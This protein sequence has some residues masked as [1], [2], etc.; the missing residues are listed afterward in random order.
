MNNVEQLIDVLAKKGLTLGSVES[1]TGGLFAK[2]ITDVSGASKVFKGALVTYSKDLKVKLLGMDE[3][4]IDDNG[5]VSW[6]VAQQM[7]L[8]GQKVLGVDVC[9][10]F[11]GN[12]GPD[13]LPGEAGVGETYMAIVYNKRIWAIPLKL[14]LEREKVREAAVNAIIPTLISIL[15]K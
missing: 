5:L 13:V 10:S 11:T 4:F 14:E 7:A 2:T 15:G 6:G 3:E 8:Q 1:F 12:A 9:V